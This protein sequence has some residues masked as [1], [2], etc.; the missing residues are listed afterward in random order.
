MGVKFVREAGYFK[1]LIFFMTRLSIIIPVYNEKETIIPLLNKLR[2]LSIPEVEKEIIIVD[3]NSTDGTRDL[4]LSLNDGSKVLF[5]Q[6]N[7][8]K[9]AAIHTGLQSAT[10]TYTVI[11]DA[12]LEYDPEDIAVLMEVALGK[13][14]PVVYGSRNIKTARRGYFFYY[15]GGRFL[16]GLFNLLYGTKLTDIN[17]CYKLFQ[18]ELLNSLDLKEKRFTFCEEV[19]AKISLRKI[20]IEEVPI[21][22]APRTFA[23][24]K[25]I[26][27]KDGLRATYAII[28]Y[29]W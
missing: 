18:T 11:Q 14:I 5:H 20:Q 19:T 2:A 12:D 3:D 27:F 21:R 29:R 28:R 15:L 16:S 25:K 1:T 4:L 13:N 22:Y 23:E 24:G 17:T 26:R 10:G 7:A 8:G 6:T 9:G